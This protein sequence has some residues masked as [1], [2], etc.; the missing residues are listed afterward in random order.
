[1]EVAVGWSPEFNNLAIK[2]R[3]VVLI[4]SL[5]FLL[6]QQSGLL[7]RLKPYQGKSALFE[8]LPSCFR[9]GFEVSDNGLLVAIDPNELVNPDVILI[10]SGSLPFE[11]LNLEKLMSQIRIE[12]NADF[13]DILSQLMRNIELNPGDWI[14]PLLGDVVGHRC[15]VLLQSIQSKVIKTLPQLETVLPHI[16]RMATFL[17]QSHQTLCKLDQQKI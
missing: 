9:L 2:M 1:M 4:A 12:G 16:E 15:E 3:H 6:K 10:M 8:W 5:N 14:H 7:D 11:P 17:N 13:A